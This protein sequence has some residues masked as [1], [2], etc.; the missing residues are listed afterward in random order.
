MGVKESHELKQLETRREKLKV[1]LEAR[2]RARDEAVRAHSDVLCK[3]QAVEK[4]IDA[5]QKASAKPVV[6]EH[7]MLRYLERVRGLD[8][9]A[10]QDEILNDSRLAA[11]NTL[12]SCRLPL[13]DGNLLLVENRTVKSVIPDAAAKQPA[14]AGK[15]KGENR[16]PKPAQRRRNSLEEMELLTGC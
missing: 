11:I 16:G 8:L 12:Q 6:T 13:G 3:L 1:E 4:S 7:A 9:Q 2:A 5:L 14:R 15:S 10:L